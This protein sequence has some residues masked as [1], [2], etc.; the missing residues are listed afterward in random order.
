VND[1][2]LKEK[3][4]VI[5]GGTK[6]VGRAAAI[7]CSL[8]GA[9]VV[10]GG[11]DSAAAED[12]LRQISNLGGEGRYV[13]TDLRRVQH[14]EHLFEQAVRDF[15]R[16]DG[17][18][19]YAGLTSAASL[20]ECEEKLFDEV[21]ET[22]IRAAFFCAKSAV[23]CMLKTGGGSIVMM[24]SLHAW[25]GEKDRAAYACS[26]GALVTLSEHI[27]H[28]Y[29]SNHIRCNLITMGWSPTEGELHFR[30][31]KGMK[32][33]QVRAM[34]SGIISMGR[35][36]EAEDYLP[37]IIYLLSDA[38]SMVTGSNLKISGGLSL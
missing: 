19:N 7:E 9:K 30:A 13:Y 10:F 28:H 31:S 36:Q 4:V 2:I 16:V 15:G 29:A 1:L 21:F 3:V 33:D 23:R 5:S 18:V 17:F 14:C 20:T 24:G 8:Q 38:S 32:P 25:R 35:M 22:N 27:A 12:I 11:R 26:K 6:G 34:A 37:G